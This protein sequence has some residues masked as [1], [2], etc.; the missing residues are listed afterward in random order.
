[1]KKIIVL[2]LMSIFILSGAVYADDSDIITQVFDNKVVIDGHIFQNRAL[3]YPFLIVDKMVYMPLDYQTLRAVGFLTAWDDDNKVFRVYATS[4]KPYTFGKSDVKWSSG[5]ISLSKSEAK[6]KWFENDEQDNCMLYGNGIL[7]LE[8]SNEIL[9]YCQWAMD[10][11]DILG[12]QMNFDGNFDAFTEVEN[13][14]LLHRDA[15]AKFMMSRNKNLPY[16][17][18]RSYVTDIIKASEANDIGEMWIMAI[19]WQESWYDKNCEYKGALGIMQIM[20]STGKALGLSKKQLFNPHLSIEYGVKYLKQQVD[21][22]NG[23]LDLGILSYNQGPVR[24]SKGKYSTKYLNQV[25]KKR[26]T[27]KEWIIKYERENL[28]EETPNDK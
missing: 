10:Y 27:I 13:S 8:L 21:H 25:K 17:E 28:I 18:A 5:Q 24:V 11:Q 4:N 19:L 15:M 14:E 6:F 7:Y 2:M 16:D 23:N 26:E 22:F 1:M 12:L 3:Q 9:K 20:G